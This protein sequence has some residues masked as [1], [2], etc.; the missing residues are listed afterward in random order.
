MFPVP[1]GLLVGFLLKLGEIGALTTHSKYVIQAIPL[2]EHVN[3]LIVS[4]IFFT[5]NTARA[6]I[7]TE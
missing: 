5:V 4:C 1:V 2:Y 6:L 7:Y 3:L